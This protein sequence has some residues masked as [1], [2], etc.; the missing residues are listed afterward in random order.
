MPMI[1]RHS[2]VVTITKHRALVAR[3]SCL[4]QDRPDLKFASMQ[5]CCAMG[6]SVCARH[7]AS[8]EDWED[9]SLGSQEQYACSAGK[10]G[11][12][13]AYSDADWSG[14]RTT[15]Q[16]VSAGVIMRDGHCLK[17]WTKKQQAVS[18]ST[19]ESELHAAVKTA[20]EA[21]GIRSLAKVICG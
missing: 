18:L 19:A 21:I 3:I 16:S 11:E 12:L 4:S 17:V 20:S 15:R 13:E 5:V 6:T 14:D 7:G 8:G 10:R 2:Q 9:T 1:A